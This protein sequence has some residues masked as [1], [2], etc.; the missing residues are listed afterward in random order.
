M[1]VIVRSMMV[2][3]PAETL[4]CIV[5]TLPAPA[6]S[7]TYVMVLAWMPPVLELVP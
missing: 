2:A 3:V 5:N 4:Y 6:V 1:T 7:V